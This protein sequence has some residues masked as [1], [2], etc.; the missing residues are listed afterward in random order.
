M[1]NLIKNAV[2]AMEGSGSISIALHH[3]KNIA[4]IEI[5]D[6]GKGIPKRITKQSLIR[7]SLLRNAAG[8]LA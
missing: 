6:T 3:D 1:E 4:V 2:D 7:A 5:A 8:G